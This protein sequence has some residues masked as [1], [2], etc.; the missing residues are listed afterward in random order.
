MKLIK[1]F[2]IAIATGAICL[3]LLFGTTIAYKI[4][5]NPEIT[6]LNELND[7]NGYTIEKLDKDWFGNWVI[8]KKGQKE[9]VFKCSDSIFSQLSVKKSIGK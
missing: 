8:A 3:Y 9:V 7:Y 1:V 5:S 2:L 6:E 4:I